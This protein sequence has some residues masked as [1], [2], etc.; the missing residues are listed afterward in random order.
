MGRRRRRSSRQQIP[1]RGGGGG[2]LAMGGGHA[3]GHGAEQRRIADDMDV[4]VDG[5]FQGHRIHR[6]P[7][8]RVRQARRGG[9]RARLL[10]RNEIDD[11]ALVPF[12]ELGF[13]GHPLAVD[14]HHLA[15]AGQ[16]HPFD[17]A[18]VKL[19]PAVH[20]QG[21][22]GKTF[23]GIEDENF[24]PRL[25][26]FQPVRDEAGALVRGGQASVQAG[27]RRDDHHAAV[28]HGGEL[29]AQQSRLRPGVP[30]VGDPLAGGPVVP[31]HRAPA[32]TDA[33]RHHQ[34][35][36]FKG[37]AVA[38][39]HGPARR[40]DGHRRLAHDPDTVLLRQVVIGVADGAHAPQPGDHE[41]AERAGVIRGLGFD[42][43]HVEAAI[44]P[45]K[46]L[47]RRGAAKSAADDDNAGAPQ[48]GAR[49]AAPCRE[50]GAGEGGGG[51]PVE[52]AAVYS[53]H[54]A[55]IASTP[56]PDADRTRDVARTVAPFPTAVTGARPA[57]QKFS[58]VRGRG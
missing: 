46:G 39:A 42:Q 48:G 56:R 8:G 2:A 26:L 18:R 52:C 7:A 54:R 30:G 13:Q 31:G 25:G 4:L 40:I 57:R 32:K 24:R 36:V 47:G 34:P 10:R 20:E 35:I 37:F 50:R 44:Q 45:P 17:H 43:N 41:V 16:R 21:L 9:Q 15:V 23:L 27:G 55:P 6:A 22:L 33:R 51:K 58:P 11:V 1:H 28:L 12:S 29:P 38:E 5:R 53:G 3:L 49:P 14:A 19:L